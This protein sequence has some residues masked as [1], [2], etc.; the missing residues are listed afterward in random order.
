M[1]SDYVNI[2]SSVCKVVSFYAAFVLWASHTWTGLS[3]T[4]GRW[5][6]IENGPARRWRLVSDKISAAISSSQN[7]LLLA[8][9]G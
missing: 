5:S 7:T 2:G 6:G 9:P 3:T 1:V 8:W 4:E